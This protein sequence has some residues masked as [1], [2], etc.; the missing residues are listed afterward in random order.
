MINGNNDSNNT[1]VVIL[2]M[3]TMIQLVMI[4]RIV[5]KIIATEIVITVK[6]ATLTIRGTIR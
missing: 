4:I 5:F 1:T 2:I 3:I 6:A